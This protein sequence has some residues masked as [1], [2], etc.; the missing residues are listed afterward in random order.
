[1]TQCHL[2][3]FLI[4]VVL[5]EHD[6]SRE[7]ETHLETKTIRLSDIIVHE[8]YGRVEANG[9]LNDIA[10]L[11]LSEEVDISLYTPVCLPSSVKERDKTEAVTIGGDID[12]E[13]IG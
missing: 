13:S 4:K 8:D 1:M 11:E 6:S 2:Y 12:N 9:F 7:G 10:L 3:K 5:G